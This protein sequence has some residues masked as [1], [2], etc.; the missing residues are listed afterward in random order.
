MARSKAIFS[1]PSVFFGL[2]MILKGKNHNARHKMLSIIPEPVAAS[3]ISASLLSMTKKMTN[4]LPS[5]Y[6]ILLRFRGSALCVCVEPDNDL[7]LVS[8]AKGVPMFYKHWRHELSC[9]RF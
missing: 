1:N 4:K 3:R 7:C 2:A 5:A 9:C 6:I 8:I